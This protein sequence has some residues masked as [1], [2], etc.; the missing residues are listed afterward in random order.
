[1][2]LEAIEKEKDLSKWAFVKGLP[3]AIS[4]DIVKVGERYGVVY[5]L[6]N[7]RCASDYIKESEGN[8][9]DF[10]T[11]SADLLD[12]I[13]SIEVAP[14]ELPDMKLQHYEWI[15]KCR[16]YLPGDVGDWL[17]GLLDAV[18]DSHTL[19]HAD[20]HLK[21]IMVSGDELV[22]IDMDTL[23]AGDP[24]FEMAT[25][26]NSY[27][28]FPSISPQAAEFLGITVEIADRIWEGMLRSFVKNAGLKDVAGL[29]GRARAFGCVRI[30]DY[31]D[32]NPDLPERE[33]CI[34]TC[35]NDITREYQEG[36]IL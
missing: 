25:I 22:L 33:L 29:T 32:N 9:G 34:T 13:H 28:E 5:E 24:I 6:L 26:Y 7:A 8:M 17:K 14:G 30:I 31:M 12:L 21:N 16:R 27:K 1:M 2:S 11:K 19:L 15:D 20:Y 18:P 3:T 10:L 23:C 36:I 35:V 4:F